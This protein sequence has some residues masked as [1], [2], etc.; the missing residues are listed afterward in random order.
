MYCNKRSK[1]QQKKGQALIPALVS[2]HIHDQ[3]QHSLTMVR[4]YEC[5]HWIRNLDSHLNLYL[6][7]SQD[8]NHISVECNSL[9][10]LVC[11]PCLHSG[12]QL[13]EC[14]ISIC[15][16]HC[17]SPK[18]ACDAAGY[19]INEW[20]SASRNSCCPN[21]DSDDK[22]DVAALY[23]GLP[24]CRSW[25]QHMTYISFNVLTAPMTEL[26]VPLCQ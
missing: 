20:V 19:R 22:T 26:L 17:Y 6:Y 25:D 12:L 23:W 15:A 18:G 24:T 3:C 10:D 5:P 1:Q 13:W 7:F 11:C 8:M 16:I 21:D 14:R 4:F 2:R 9:I